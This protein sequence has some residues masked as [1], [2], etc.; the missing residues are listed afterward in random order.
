M[1]LMVRRQAQVSSDSI[2]TP[3]SSLAFPI[4]SPHCMSSGQ[5]FVSANLHS[6]PGPSR[7][8]RRQLLSPKEAVP[9][10]RLHWPRTALH[11][12]LSP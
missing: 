8:H 10:T 7:P 1:L 3:F 2:N 6:Q 11:L 4:A 5:T 9:T 12:T